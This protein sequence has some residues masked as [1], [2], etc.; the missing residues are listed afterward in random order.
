MMQ[1]TREL[2]ARFLSAVNSNFSRF[3]GRK[4]AQIALDDVLI[5]FAIRGFNDYD[6]LWIG[7]N[8]SE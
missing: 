1:V 5:Y 4:Y 8:D 3:R 7:K 2:Y 6:I